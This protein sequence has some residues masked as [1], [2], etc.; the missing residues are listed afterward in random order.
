VDTEFWRERWE[1]GQT[2]FNQA[3][4]NHLLTKSWP[5]LALRPGCSVFVPLCGKTID[6]VWL[7]ERGH[8]VIGNEVSELAVADFFGEHDLEPTIRS[9][10]SMAVYTA[11]EYELWCGDFF[12]LTEGAL[13]GVDAVYD[14]ASLVALPADM[15]RRYADHLAEILPPA[16]AMLVV[17]FEYEQSEMDGPPFS[18]TQD[19]IRDLFSGF[20]MQA[21]ADEDVFESNA[22][23]RERGL[24]RLRETAVALH[25]S[26]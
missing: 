6:M 11:A 15:R 23:L 14:R 17:A 25:R 1:L 22:D 10:G 2:R 16:V 20:D 13:S 9:E 18:V 26:A 12:D 3:T 21:L 8:T 4:P 7:A 24:S 19:E 5:Q